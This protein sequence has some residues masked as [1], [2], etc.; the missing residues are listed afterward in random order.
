MEQGRVFIAIVLSLLV[1]VVWDFFFV[2]RTATVPPPQVQDQQAASTAPD[3]TAAPVIPATQALAPTTPALSSTTE[4]SPTA[5]ENRRVIVVKTPLYTADLSELGGNITGFTLMNYRETIKKDSPFKQLISE[6]NPLGSARLD[7]PGINMKDLNYQVNVESDQITV[8]DK[9]EAISFVGRMPDGVIVQKTFLFSPDTYL[10]DLV[11][12][13]KNAS[14]H[15]ISVGP[16]VS[17]VHYEPP[18]LKAGYGFTGPSGYINGSLEEVKKKK[19]AEQDGLTGNISWVAILEQYFVTSI[20]P[21]NRE[22]MTM[23]LALKDSNFIHNQLVS[24]SLTLNP[25]A[26]NT[27]KYQ[28]FFGP[29]SLKILKSFDNDLAELIYFGWFDV[30]AKP[31]LWLM[32]FFH[33]NL[34]GNYGIA[35]ILLTLLIKIALWPLGQKSYKSMNEMKKL[36]P[37]TAE[38]KEKYKH[39]KKKMNEETMALYRAYKVNPMGGCLPMVVQIPVFFG[40]YRMLYGAIELRHAPFFGWISDLS[41]P[42]RLFEFSFSI[43]FMQAP[44]GIPVLTLV[45]GATMF[46]Q[47]KLQ[48]AMGDA[49]QAKMMMMMPIFFTFIF[50]NFPSGLVLYWLVNNVFSIAQQHFTRSTAK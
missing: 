13:I 31:C 33:D 22:N 29:K 41:A 39:D 15:A 7:L 46:L 28:L 10:I 6:E 27:F 25:N 11:V 49:T 1:F 8:R 3:Q 14:D 45:M 9:S 43:P 16:A 2:N 35:I 32:N 20:V 40:L 30:L 4:P 42:D 5:G 47:Q 17:L 38:I 19:I 34:I 21:V 50:I 44:Y 36:Q 12:T 26:E 18:D 48:P 23:K 24:P 37:L